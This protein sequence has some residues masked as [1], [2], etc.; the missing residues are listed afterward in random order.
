M[1][2]VGDTLYR[3]TDSTD[4]HGIVWRRID[5]T[6][7]TS[8]SDSW[9]YGTAPE[10]VTFPTHTPPSWPAIIWEALP[11]ALAVSLPVNDLGGWTTTEPVL[12]PME[13]LPDGTRDDYLQFT[14]DRMVARERGGLRAV[15]SSPE[16]ARAF[17]ILEYR[18][19]LKAW[20]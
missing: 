19:G 2:T 15:T 14:A 10:S 20:R 9:L 6:T 7:V 1:P 11:G 3:Q 8:V 17:L 12:P 4:Q 13:T 16:Q 18:E 5:R